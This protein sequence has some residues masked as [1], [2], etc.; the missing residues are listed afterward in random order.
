L[1]GADNS[2]KNNKGMTALHLAK[3]KNITNIIE[4]LSNEDFKSANSNFLK[5]N[6]FTGNAHKFKY[7]NMIAF[8]LLHLICIYFGYFILCQSIF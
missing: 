1:K 4:M 7:A 8:F 6:T 5:L 2:I 3:S